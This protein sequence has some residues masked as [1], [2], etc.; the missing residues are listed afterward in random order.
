VKLD[1]QGQPLGGAQDFITGWLAQGEAKKGRW[2]GRPV[3]IVVGADGA[4]Y[5]SDD[6]AS[7]IYRIS[8]EK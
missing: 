1:D 5:L 2:M 8:Y 4:M 6:A 7:V 3:G